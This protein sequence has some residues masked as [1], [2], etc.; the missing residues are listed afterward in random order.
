MK[1]FFVERKV[2]TSRFNPFRNTKR[3]KDEQKFGGFAKSS[4]FAP[5]LRENVTKH[6][7]MMRK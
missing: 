1:Q 7:K 3:K 4:N 5:R 6:C 2:E